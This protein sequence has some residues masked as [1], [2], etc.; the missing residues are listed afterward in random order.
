MATCVWAFIF[1][2]KEQRHLLKNKGSKHKLGEK[3]K[4]FLTIISVYVR[5]CID[6]SICVYIYTYILHTRIYGF[7]RVFFFYLHTV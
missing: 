6:V 1:T 4:D 2:L 7:M 5:T 3:N